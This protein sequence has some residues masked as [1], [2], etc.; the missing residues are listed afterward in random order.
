MEELY[1][2]SSIATVNRVLE[3]VGE[4]AVR[5]WLAQHWS[6]EFLDADE[7]VLKRLLPLIELPQC[8]CRAATVLR[9][10]DYDWPWMLDA[11]D[12]AA[13]GFLPAFWRDA[14]ERAQHAGSARCM[15]WL[16]DAK[17]EAI[18]RDGSWLEL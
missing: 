8:R 4:D 5:N 6:V 13:C 16:L 3:S 17:S 7:A 9:A 1:P 2:W 14:F 18:G 12:S 11:A 10:I 15:A